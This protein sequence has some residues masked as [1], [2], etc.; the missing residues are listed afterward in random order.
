M[1]KERFFI[2]LSNVFEGYQKFQLSNTLDDMEKFISVLEDKF[3]VLG[4]KLI[5]KISSEDESIL[6]SINSAFFDSNNNEFKLTKYSVFDKYYS[7]ISLFE[8]LN[9]V[10]TMS[11]LEKIEDFKRY[12]KNKEEVGV[13]DSLPELASV[14]S[15]LNKLVFKIKIPNPKM[16]CLKMIDDTYSYIY[17]L[18]NITVDHIGK[19]LLD[20]KTIYFL[21][22]KENEVLNTKAGEYL[23]RTIPLD[24]KSSYAFMQQILQE[25]LD[26]NYENLLTRHLTP[27][28]HLFIPNERLDYLKENGKSKI[29]A[30]EKSEVHGLSREE[31]GKFALNRLIDFCFGIRMVYIKDYI[32]STD[33]IALEAYYMLII[34][35]YNRIMLVLKENGK[36]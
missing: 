17:K 9:Q 2:F 24:I 29:I 5:N 20:V 4:G 8:N 34:N 7:Q 10:A 14:C 36:V 12:L 32:Y 33:K 1:E 22:E 31:Q 23:T 30:P 11:I 3:T 19:I 26:G 16:N 21:I 28:Y 27:N 25:C 35:S 13:L 18:E 15:S 6:R